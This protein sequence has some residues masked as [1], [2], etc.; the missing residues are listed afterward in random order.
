MV[1]HYKYLVRRSDAILHN[2]E[3]ATYSKR[4]NAQ[5]V[6]LNF[7]EIDDHMN[8]SEMQKAH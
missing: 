2:D 5:K 8:H 1:A 4:G 6:F 3:L 7:W